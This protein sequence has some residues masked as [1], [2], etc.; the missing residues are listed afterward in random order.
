MKNLLNQKNAVVFAPSSRALAP[1]SGIECNIFSVKKYVLL[2]SILVFMF[3]HASGEIK[4]GY[5]QDV[6]QMRASLRR[7]WALLHV[8]NNF[9]LH[10]RRKIE[11]GIDSLV[12]NISN[13]ELTENLLKQFK[14]I[15]P[16][17]YAEIDTLKD[18][19]GRNVN[20]FVKFIPVNETKIKAWGTTYMSEIKKDKNAFCSEYGM[21]TVSVKIWIVNKALFVLAHELGHVKHQVPH[22]AKYMEYYKN[23]YLL[24]IYQR[25]SLGHNSKDPSG[26]SAMEYV[27]RFRKEYIYF[28]KEKKEKPQTPLMLMTRIKRDLAQDGVNF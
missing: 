15:S 7:Q 11:H 20:V 5:E 25:A 4:N 14:V 10:Q 8:N 28:L 23:N 27:K 3:N 24:Q 17:L 18:I 13:F 26:K 6:V 12:N 2:F 9:T 16:D 21:N 19:N 22:F 1:V